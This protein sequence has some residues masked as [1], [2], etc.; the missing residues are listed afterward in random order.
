VAVQD[1]TPVSADKR[2]VVAVLGHGVVTVTPDTANITIGV[3]VTKPTLQQAQSEATTQMTAVVQ[4]IKAAGVAENDIQTTYYNVSARHQYDNTTQRHEFLGYQIT[5]R[6]SVTVRDLEKVGTLLEDVV[7]VGANSIY[8]ISFG[9]ADPS[10]AVSRARAAAVDDAMRR[11]EELARAAG[12][13]LGR[14][15]S[16]S[17]GVEHPIPHWGIEELAVVANLS[18]PPPVESGSTEIAVDVQMTYELI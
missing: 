10:E 6:V 8:G 13:T 16:I 5:S 12:V 15:L 17:E 18:P 2:A 11:A 4:A 9:A 7:A 3:D 1:S 14:V